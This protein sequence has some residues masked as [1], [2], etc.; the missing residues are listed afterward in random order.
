[1]Y[2]IEKYRKRWKERK[3]SS[4]LWSIFQVSYNVIFLMMI[5]TF[6]KRNLVKIPKISEEHRWGSIGISSR[7]VGNILC[8]WLVR[9]IGSKMRLCEASSSIGKRKKKGRWFQRMYLHTLKLYPLLEKTGHRFV[10]LISRT[11]PRLGLYLKKSKLEIEL[12]LIA[13]LL[14]DSFNVSLKLILYISTIFWL[15]C[16][17]VS[18]NSIYI[19]PYLYYFWLIVNTS[20]TCYATLQLLVMP[21]QN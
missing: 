6:G 13:S 7:L 11:L 15:C 12:F 1:M 18:C 14:F 8:L 5:L 4:S 21:V 17:V 3:R 16:C 19:V 2:I 9:S 20:G 10:I